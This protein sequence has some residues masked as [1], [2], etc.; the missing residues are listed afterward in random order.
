MRKIDPTA[1]VEDGATIGDDT[2]IGPFCTIGRD[3]VIGAGCKLISHV[4]VD[5]HTRI[6]DGTTIYPFASLGTPPQS[7]GYKGEPTRLEIGK[8]CMIRKSVTINRGTVGG[9]GVTRAGD[10]GFFMTGSHLGHDCLVGNDV[11]FANAAILGG[12]CEIGDFTFIG[13]M[14]VLQQFT[15]VGAQVM[16]GGASGLR[17]DVIPYGLANGIY[18]HLSGLNIVGMRRRKFTKQRLVVV[19]SFFDD[20]FHGDGVFTDR[21]ERVRS[22][23]EEDPAIAE[24]IAFIDDGKARSG[25]HRSLC[26]PKAG[27]TTS[28]E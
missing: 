16:I 9:G 17:D 27:E 7:T 15:R 11:I 10:R 3:V 25:R 28:T 14:T 19:R 21:L 26:M 8:D 24:I 1:R 2:T 23:A 22:R 18:A 4:N 13:G 5:G 20:L 12:H 6:G